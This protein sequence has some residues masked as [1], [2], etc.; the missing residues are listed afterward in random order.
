MLTSQTQKSTPLETQD[1]LER[2]EQFSPAINLKSVQTLSLIEAV[3]ENDQEAFFKI[4]SLKTDSFGN[5]FIDE[6]DDK[7]GGNALYW[8]AALGHMH[9]IAPLVEAGTEVN[10]PNKI[11]VTP[12][13]IA[14]QNGHS[15]TIAALYAAGANVNT[16]DKN[17]VTSVFIAAHG[18]HA[19]AITTL[20]A[21]GANVNAS[22]KTR[23]ATPVMMAAQRGHVEAIIAL[24]AA[25]A[26]VNTPE[27][28]YGATPVFMAA[29][30]GH[31]EAI[32]VLKAAGANVNTPT[33]DGATPVFATAQLGK[34]GAMIALLEAGADARIKTKL[35][36]A[37]EYARRGREPGHPEVVRVLEAHFKRYSNGIKPVRNM[38]KEISLSAKPSSLSE[39][40]NPPMLTKFNQPASPVSKTNSSQLGKTFKNRGAD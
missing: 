10:K 11:G 12:V 14:A 13:Y 2:Q 31:A 20:H 4:L 22:D 27:T 26:N 36:T 21:L 23:G 40:K 7:Y 39:Q 34:A 1:A 5:R 32:T 18:G 30:N 24:K 17:G 15:E 38:K 6:V 37:L 9:F 25:G 16:L 28:M 8:A 35:G 3:K 19:S 33:N 29:Q